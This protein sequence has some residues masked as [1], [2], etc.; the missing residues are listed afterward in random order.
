MKGR[1]EEEMANNKNICIKS[2]SLY[3]KDD[4]GD[5]D[6]SIEEDEKEEK[7]STS[8][9]RNYIFE[10]S[11]NKKE[12]N[13]EEQEEHED[14]KCHYKSI[15]LSINTE[16]M[17]NK[18][19][20]KRKP[21]TRLMY[22]NLMEKLIHI[23]TKHK[24]EIEVS[25]KNDDTKYTEILNQY[26]KNLEYE[27]ITLKNTYLYVLI[28]KHYCNDKVIKRNIIV[29]GNIPQKRNNVK[30]CFIELMNYIQNNLEENK[31]TQK[32]YYILIINILTK[33]SNISD[34]D[35]QMAKNLYKENKLDTLYYFGENVENNSSENVWIRQK[36]SNKGIIK[37]FSVAIPFAY[38]ILYFYNNMRS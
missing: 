7:I 20:S 6:E 37:L 24:N 12:D 25:E 3:N 15:K 34:D 35:I 33:Y 23:V 9:Q 5:E 14:N 16:S 17:E 1:K 8:K 4:N 22:N 36:K 30:R 26:I 31:E 28:K 19:I 38:I 21:V 18:I 27:I 32:Y 10:K 2:N 29:Q 11:K 13:D